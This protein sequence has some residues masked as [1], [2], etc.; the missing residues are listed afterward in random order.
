MSGRETKS[1]HSMEDGLLVST[2]SRHGGVDVEGVQVARQPENKT[3]MGS[4]KSCLPYE[5][6]L[7]MIEMW[8]IIQLNF[9]K[10]F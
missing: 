10:R 8:N 9:L 4:S 6:S 5:I 7:L 2:G 1:G 3:C